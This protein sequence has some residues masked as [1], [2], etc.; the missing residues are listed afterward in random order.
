MELIIVVAIALVIIGM[1]VPAFVSTRRNF[2]S[3]TDASNVSGEIL[4]AKMRAS[5]SFTQSRVY[6]D[7]AANTFRIEIWDKTASAWVIDAPSGEVSLSPDVSWGFGA[8][9]NPPPGTQ[10]AIAQAPACVDGASGAAPG[11]A[12]ASTAC[13]VFNSRGIPIDTSAAPAAE[14]AI[15]ITDGTSV[16]ATTMSITGHLQKWRIDVNDTDATHWNE[17]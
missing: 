8:Q 5:S 4:L 15:Y 11:T 1:A 9:T 6:F 14:N 2:R 17:R 7:L 10:A 13:I 12:I 16:Y 3:I